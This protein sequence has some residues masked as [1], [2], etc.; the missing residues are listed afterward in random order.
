VNRQDL[1]KRIHAVTD[2]YADKHFVYTG[3][4]HGDGYVNYRGLGTPDNE[5]LCTE[6]SVELLILSVLTMGF[7]IYKPIVVIGPRSMGAQMVTFI[8]EHFQPQ[9][10]TNVRTY[11]LKK[12]S[13]RG[14]F[15]W[16]TDEKLTFSP[17]TQ[18]VWMDDLLNNGTTVTTTRKM[19]EACGGRINVIAVIGDRSG[20]TA[21]DLGADHIISLERF[22]LSRYELNDEP[23][24]LC[25]KKVPIVR[26]PG[27]GHTFEK[28]NPDYPGGFIDL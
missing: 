27:H 13:E 9:D 1:L 6:V 26:N 5:V 3:D 21:S 22:D 15:V 16:S 20:L 17:D 14:Q 23:C 7:D 12:G 28:E 2:V 10:T 24:P 25:E 18:I 19:I 8:R 4:A 11:I